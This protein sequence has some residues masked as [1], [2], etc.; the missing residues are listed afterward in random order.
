M[1][2]KKKHNAI[3]NSNIDDLNCYN[4]TIETLKLI[5]KKIDKRLIAVRINFDKSSLHD[6]DQILKDISFLDRKKSYI[7]VKKVWQI[8]T[9]QVDRE[10]ILD[11]IQ[12]IFDLDFLVDY[13]VMP[14]GGVCFAE[15][16]NQA[17]FNYD[18]KIFKCTTI[19]NF[20][21]RNTLG[22]YSEK[23]GLIKWEKNKIKEWTRNMQQKE[24]LVCKWYG[25]CYGPCNKQLIK[26]K[27]KFICTFDSMNL[28][29]KEYL[30]YLFKYNLLYRKLF[31]K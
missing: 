26:H 24:C 29:N 21:E 11:V 30:I 28:T 8:N 12:K 16:K 6:I 20:D 15:R 1:V 27:N 2:L 31:S 7:I 5:D 14:K 25:A 18:G 23:T 22:C 17:L 9:Q 13:Y 19:S 3:K 10:I 4:K